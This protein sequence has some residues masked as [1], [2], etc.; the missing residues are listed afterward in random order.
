MSKLRVLGTLLGIFVGFNGLVHATTIKAPASLIDGFES[1]SGDDAYSWGI[2]IPMPA[3]EQV[4]SAEVDFTGIELKVAS[5]G[6]GYL[7]TDLLNS[8]AT[9]VT[10]Q[11]NSGAP[12][13]YWATQFSGA[14]I[15]PLGEETFNTP[16]TTLTWSYVLTSAEL[17]AL[18]SYLTDHGGI[19]NLGIDPDC[20][21]MVGSLS[22]TY[23]LDPHNNTVP[24]FAA[25]AFLLVMGLAGLGVFRRQFVAAKIRA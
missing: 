9:G 8:K 14:N 20:Q 17:T 2:S 21:Y 6:K 16:G 13:D 5:S 3:G 24:D 25:T 18:N 12:G 15:T 22:F 19:F 11:V 7:Y 1:S 4:V 10:S 23:N